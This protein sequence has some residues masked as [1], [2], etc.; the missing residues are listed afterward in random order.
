MSRMQDVAMNLWREVSD[1]SYRFHRHEAELSAIED[2]SI[3]QIRDFYRERIR[4][5]GLK[6]RLLVISVGPD[7]ILNRLDEILYFNPL[8]EDELKE[9]VGIAD[10]VVVLSSGRVTGEFDGHAVSE[11]ELVEASYVG[12]ATS[13]GR[14]SA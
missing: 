8:G 14:E 9:V 2:I 4:A 7:A 13:P 1:R 12:H 6:R 5:D 3:E 10:R 11:Q